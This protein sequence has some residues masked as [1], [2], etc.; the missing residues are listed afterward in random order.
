MY[1]SISGQT[2][3][4]FCWELFYRHCVE[5]E[6]FNPDA[7]NVANLLPDALFETAFKP[8]RNQSSI[9]RA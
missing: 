6:Y 3:K 4:P 1:L 8:L 5:E 7:L 2:G 9:L